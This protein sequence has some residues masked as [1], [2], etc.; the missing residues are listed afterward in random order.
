MRSSKDSRAIGEGGPEQGL[1]WWFRLCIRRGVTAVQWDT[2]YGT[3]TEGLAD[4]L[5]NALDVVGLR[6]QIHQVH[7][8]DAITAVRQVNQI[9]GERRR[10]TRHIS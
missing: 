7:L 1:A 8:L 2:W 6:K 4:Q 5:R 3:R 10:V 9:A